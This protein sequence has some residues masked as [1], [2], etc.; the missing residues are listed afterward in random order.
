MQPRMRRLSAILIT[1]LLLGESTSVMA[2]GNS[3]GS[4]GAGDSAADKPA[5]HRVAHRPDN[6]LVRQAN[7]RSALRDQ[8][9]V[10]VSYLM[11]DAETRREIYAEMAGDKIGAVTSMPEPPVRVP[12]DQIQTSQTCS[13]EIT[14]PARATIG[15]LTEAEF[16]DIRTRI[17]SSPTSQITKSPSMIV[18]DGIE[19]EMNNLAQFPIV[20]DAA[21]SGESV[22]DL[23]AKTVTPTIRIYDQ[24]T[25][26][27]LLAS[28]WSADGNPVADST[29]KLTIEGTTS[30]IDEVAVDEIFG[31]D[32]P[33]TTKVPQHQI[34]T[35][36]VVETLGANQALW[37]DMHFKQ[38]KSVRAETPVPIINK[39][40]YVG[41]S[42]K[43]V[44]DVQVD[45]YLVLVLQPSV[46]ASSS[47]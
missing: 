13:H 43:N 33:M 45:Q 17:D 1:S 10:K 2:Q 5:V 8:I 32:Q 7:L 44:H 29:I 22:G 42:F 37:L 11:I 15:V 31:G 28:V 47:R 12:L 41:R 38:P 3:L 34:K 24:G 30:V 39:V 21:S 6:P 26:V 19:A 4:F 14:V 40:P 9:K 25:R 18:L 23:A 16:R 35:V 27:R 20:I 46:I 36:T